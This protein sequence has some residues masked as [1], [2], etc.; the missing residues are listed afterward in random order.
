M[1]SSLEMSH[2]AGTTAANK[3]V[4]RGTSVG[5]GTSKLAFG[6]E[7]DS[8]STRGAAGKDTVGPRIAMSK[9]IYI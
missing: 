8:V 3:V 5:D 6:V 7:D 4:S 1:N 9:S 2:L